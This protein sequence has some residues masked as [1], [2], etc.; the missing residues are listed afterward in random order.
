MAEAVL[1]G[2]SVMTHGLCLP[3]NSADGVAYFSLG[4]IIPATT[5]ITITP[6]GGGGDGDSAFDDFRRLRRRRQRLAEEARADAEF[7]ALMVAVVAALND[8][9]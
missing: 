1:D 2:I 3:D 9:D 7:L 5:G 4:L 6:G 8:E